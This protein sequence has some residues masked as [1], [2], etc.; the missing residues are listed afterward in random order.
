VLLG[1]GEASA[2]A[3]GLCL[4]VPAAGDNVPV[5][6]GPERYIELVDNSVYRLRVTMS[7]DQTDPSAIPF[8]SIAHDNFNQSGFGNT[9]GGESFVLDSPGGANG[10]G[11]P[12]GRTEFD[13]YIAPIALRAPQWRLG[14]FLP[15]AD[16]YND[17]R[18][19]FRL[20]DI[21]SAGINA[22]AD[23]GTVCIESIQVDRFSLGEFSFGEVLYNAPISTS[24][25]APFTFG[26]S[27]LLA[28]ID[29][30]ANLARYEL[31]PAGDRATLIPAVEP[32]STSNLYPVVWETD[33]LYEVTL[34]QSGEASTEADPID[35]TFLTVD[36]ATN[37]LIQNG[38]TTRGSPNNMER[39]GSPR[40]P[41]A[42]GGPQTYTLFF[43]GNNATASPIENVN[44]LRPMVDLWNVDTIAG[45]E[46]G[47]DPIEI[48]GLQVRRVTPPR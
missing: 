23:S 42:T 6:A 40:Q 9:F 30:E 10:I 24:T 1:E 12:N 46:S 36:T 31:N 18:L 45:P 21:G 44:R 29:D 27:P 48:L 39:A 7:T 19:I 2:G 25:H 4:T 43:H 20:L 37:E 28:E 33:Q 11:R 41:E 35:L 34:V 17:I 5:W 22:D 16:P 3:G 8:W 13:F 26:Q 32:F 38:W 14:A 15:A 47:A